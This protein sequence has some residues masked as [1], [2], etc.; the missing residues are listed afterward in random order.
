MKNIDAEPSTSPYVAP[1]SSDLALGGVGSATAPASDSDGDAPVK[2]INPD[3]VSIMMPTPMASVKSDDAPAALMPPAGKSSGK[4]V[5]RNNM[6][7]SSKE[8]NL[9]LSLGKDL[10]LGSEQGFTQCAVVK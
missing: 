10:D 9:D 1:L 4:E 8:D 3:D 6:G 2:L 5:E 7:S